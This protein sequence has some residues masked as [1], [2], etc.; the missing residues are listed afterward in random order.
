MQPIRC[1]P[2]HTSLI[3]AIE[4][5]LDNGIALDAWV[6]MSALGI[7]FITVETRVA[8]HRSNVT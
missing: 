7:D 4:R 3:D 6:R 1:A 8:S 2:G 5:V